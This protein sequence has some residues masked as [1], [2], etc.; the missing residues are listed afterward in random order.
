[1][2][3]FS[4]GTPQASQWP[5]PPLHYFDYE[6][7]LQSGDA[8]TYYYHSHV[9]LHFITAHGS[10]V[11]DERIHDSVPFEYDDDRTILFSDIFY[12]TDTSIMDRLMAMPFGFSGDDGPET[13]NIALN[14]RSR[15]ANATKQSSSCSYA[16]ITVSP[17]KTY[18]FGLTRQ[19]ILKQS[20][21][22]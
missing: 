22:Q 2:S 9:G 12:D 13:N 8:G 21:N 4:D 20:V 14:G 7:Q 5:I 3:P 16:V 19:S 6:F 11:V 17:D 18:R 15:S 1:M 10:L